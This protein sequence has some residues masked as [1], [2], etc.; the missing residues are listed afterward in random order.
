M[1][2]AL[3]DDNPKDLASL[4]SLLETYRRE[5]KA[6]LSIR[7]YANG[8]ALLDDVRTERFDLMMLD[9]MMPFVDGI[10]IA[11][12]IRGFDE[13]ARIAFLTS[14][15]EFAVESYEVD[16]FHYLLKPVTRDKLF[17]VLDKLRRTVDRQGEGLTVK[18]KGGVAGILFARIAF[19][20]VLNRTVRFH[21][22]DGSVKETAGSLSDYE[23]KLLERPEFVRAHRAFIVNL[24]QIQELDKLSLRTF[25]NESVPLSRRLSG[26]VKSAYLKRLF[27]QAEMA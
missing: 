12:E 20:E 21:M 25:S 4:A 1:R 16:A 13:G 7:T 14:S 9:V 26:E 18:L 19:V 22:T 17:A 6:N 24:D 8:V 2:I 11:R 5:T 27:L 3:C 23:S 10:Q 15:P